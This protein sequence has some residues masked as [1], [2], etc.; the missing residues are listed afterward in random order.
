[1]TNY[2]LI[3]IC[4]QLIFLSTSMRCCC[5]SL[6]VSAEQRFYDS[7]RQETRN[8][9][10]TRRYESI[11]SFNSSPRYVSVHNMWPTH[12]ETLA[13]ITLNH[14]LLFV[15]P[16]VSLYLLSY[17]FISLQR[18]HSL[19][20]WHL[21]KERAIWNHRNTTAVNWYEKYFLFRWTASEMSEYTLQQNTTE[22]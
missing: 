4:C 3:Q 1:M 7:V 9:L 16:S 12:A 14:V 11:I 17:M 18:V 5:T 10:W 22:N 13:N 21:F 15:S 6:M 19:M 8:K 20:R 2:S